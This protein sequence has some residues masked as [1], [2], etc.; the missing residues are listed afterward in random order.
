[1]RIAYVCADPG[2]PVFGTKGASVHV[3]EVVG[4]LLASGHDVDLFCRRTGGAPS[5]ALADGRES[6][7]LR[8]HVA[9]RISGSDAGDR[10]VRLMSGDVE[11][12]ARIADV[13]AE[14]SFD[15]VYERYALFSTAGTRVAAAH[16]LPSILEVNAPLPLEQ[17]AHRALVHADEADAVAR[18]AIAGATTVVCVSEGV[19]RWARTQ[20]PGREILVEPNGVNADRFTPRAEGDSVPGTPFTIGFVGT[21]KPWHGT[22]TLI[23]AFALLGVG[24]E[25][26]RL[27]IVGDGPERQSLEERATRLGVADGVEF[28]GAVDPSTVPGRL[29]ACD[30]GTAPYPAEGDAYFSPLKVIEYMAA[31]VAV[32]ASRVGQLPELVDDGRTGILVPGSDAAALAAAIRALAGDPARCREMGRAARSVV[33]EQRTWR[34]VVRRTFAGAGLVLDTSAGATR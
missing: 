9:E 28:V 18:E 26:A 22:D 29:A 14:R 7:R 15:A 32:V 10:E 16:A 23:D 19:A 33:E 30:V 25:V 5:G 21:L 27:L 17:A 31:G 20:A 1:M 8:V 13:H 3:Q 4:V 11:M 34:D 6:G 12:A 2:I 24:P